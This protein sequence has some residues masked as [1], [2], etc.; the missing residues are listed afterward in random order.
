M[1][2]TPYYESFDLID[3]ATYFIALL[4]GDV[5]FK[6]DDSYTDILINMDVVEDEIRMQLMETIG[7]AELGPPL[8]LT[9]EEEIALHTFLHI[10]AGYTANTKFLSFIE[11]NIAEKI[12]VLGEN[13]HDLIKRCN[14]Y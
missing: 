12:E 9:L 13:K 1:K 5:V 10:S 4:L 7:D 8:M 14:K 3:Q 2:S 11:K 6:N